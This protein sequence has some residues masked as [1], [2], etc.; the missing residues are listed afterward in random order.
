MLLETEI[1]KLW[2]LNQFIIII[3]IVLKNHV[4]TAFDCFQCVALSSA[5]N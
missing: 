5:I 4:L 1:I 2:A 3:T